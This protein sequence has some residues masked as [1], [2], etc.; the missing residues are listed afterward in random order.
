MAIAS[1]WM[2]TPPTQQRHIFFPES[3]RYSACGFPALNM[4][5]LTGNETELFLKCPK[6]ARAEQG[7]QTPA[8]AI[9]HAALKIAWW[10]TESQARRVAEY[11]AE[12][13]HARAERLAHERS[14]LA[15]V[16]EDLKAA[17]QRVERL[18]S[19]E[20]PVTILHNAASE[21]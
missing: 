16:V 8:A 14:L 19:A 17:R 3:P 6:C 7:E 4:A 18:Y 12:Q 1:T 2:L 5:T 21:K 15:T 9:V 20:P 11:V 10:N 13:D